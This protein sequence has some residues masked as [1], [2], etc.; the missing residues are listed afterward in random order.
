MSNCNCYH[1]GLAGLGDAGGGPAALSAAEKEVFIR[2]AKAS[3]DRWKILS[4]I[5]TAMPETGVVVTGKPPIFKEGPYLVQY[6]ASG[7]LQ[8]FDMEGHE[9]K[10]AGIEPRYNFPA[11]WLDIG[12]GLTQTVLLLLG[13]YWIYKVVTKER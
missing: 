5:S 11:G 10:A 12:F 9:A 3:V 13:G 1:G 7:I 6:D 2:E 8:I 4:Y